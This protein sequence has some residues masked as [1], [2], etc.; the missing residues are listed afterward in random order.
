LLGVVATAWGR[1]NTFMSPCE[2][3][4]ASLDSLVLTAMIMWNGRVPAGM[5]KAAAAFLKG[6]KG[7]RDWRIFTKCR[8]A[9]ADLQ[10]W[11]SWDQ[12]WCLELFE[13]A[14]HLNGEPDRVNPSFTPGMVKNVATSIIKGKMLGKEFV[15][16][17]RGLVPDKW[18]SLYVKSRV[19]PIERRY[20]CVKKAAG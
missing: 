19:M 17:H 3:I 5:E 15:K 6:F 14:A 18:N 9:A 4:E 8:K 2:S 12:R 10:A 11:Q 1:Y 13:R 20:A 7:G 16:A